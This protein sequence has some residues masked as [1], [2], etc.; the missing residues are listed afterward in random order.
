MRRESLHE[1]DQLHELN[2][3]KYLCNECNFFNLFNPKPLCGFTLVEL[4]AVMAIIAII[5]GLT[6]GAFSYA[7]RR[8]VES[9]TK[10][11]IKA[12]E[13]AIEAYKLDKG[14]YPASANTTRGT[15]S[16]AIANSKELYKALSG[17]SA[18]TSLAPDSGNRAYFTAFNDGKNG[19]ITKDSGL[20]YILDPNRS[21][22]NY[23]AGSPS[24]QTNKV[25]FDLWSFG[26]DGVNDTADD[27]ANWK[28]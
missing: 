23:I 8:S 11:E 12:L 18:G 14:A 20:Y 3:G 19:N 4:L 26:I 25:S 16:A 5:A 27:I 24:V 21:P 10:A 28:F 6:I 22:Y 17:N 15:V 2:R 13:L 7:N 1:L 9:R